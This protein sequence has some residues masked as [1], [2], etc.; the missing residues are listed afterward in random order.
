MNYITGW[1]F[2]DLLTSIPSDFF[3]KITMKNK[4]DQQSRL[5]KL[6]KIPRMY[7]L[8]KLYRVITIV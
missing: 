5:S 4:K 2:P 3:D 8:I 7:R 6:G 1:F